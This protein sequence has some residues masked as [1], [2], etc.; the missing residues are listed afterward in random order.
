MCLRLVLPALVLLAAPLSAC[1]GEVS[2]GDGTPTVSA[3]AVEGYIVDTLKTAA[4]AS[5][6]SASCPEDLEGTVDTTI[7]C[8]VTDAEGDTDVEVVVTA[9]DGTDVSFDLNPVG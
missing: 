4:G 6:D 3:S 8:T 2:V 7:T 5:P 9:V 1:S